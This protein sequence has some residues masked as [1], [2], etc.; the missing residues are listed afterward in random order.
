M[1]SSVFLLLT[2]TV[3]AEIIYTKYIYLNPWY[4]SAKTYK[5]LHVLIKNKRKPGNTGLHDSADKH[6]EHIVGPEQGNSPVKSYS[7]NK[8]L[9]LCSVKCECKNTYSMV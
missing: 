1:L 5:N 4:S 2:F 8:D 9:C 3:R 7:P 6:S